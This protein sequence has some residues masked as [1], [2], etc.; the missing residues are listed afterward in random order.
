MKPVPLHALSLLLA[1]HAA[2]A[3]TFVVTRLDDP[4][5]DACV[6]GD[7]S[8]RE[9]MQAANSNDEFAPDDVIQLGA[10]SHVLIRGAL[11]IGQ[12]LD[13]R[14]AGSTQTSVSSDADLFVSG[15]PGR[16]NVTGMT[17]D[18]TTEFTSAIS[19]GS[20]PVEVDDVIV[21]RG[22]V[23]A[24]GDLTLRTSELRGSFQCSQAEGHCTVEDSHVASLYAV[25]PA[26]EPGATITIRRSIVDGE[27]R[28]DY[29][30]NGIV[31]HGGSLLV[32]D[33]LLMHLNVGVKVLYATIPMTLR[34][35]HYLDNDEPV[36]TEVA[37]TI[38]IED[39]LF[40]GNLVRALYAAG[41]A[42]W[43]VRGS[44][45]VNN[46][47]NGNAGGAIVIED[48]T[49]V[50]IEN[51]SFSGN[52]F[53]V[54]AAADG[55]RGGAIGFRNAT[56]IDLELRHV[57]I[58]PPTPPPAGAQGL[59]LGGVGGGSAVT[60]NVDNSILRGSCR[61]DAGA[62][63]HASGNI[64]SLGD[65]C[66]L[67][68]ASN[69]VNASAS[70]LAIGTLGD[71]GG[72]TPTYE[73]GPDSVAIDAGDPDRCLDTDQ[74]GYPRPFGA[75]CDVGAVEVGADDHLFSDGFEG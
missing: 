50:L 4:L 65:T 66:G 52:T 30:L 59:G 71:H 42:N 60:I 7:C 53:T 14:G 40:E 45:F 61:L 25:T 38:T 37:A 21:L 51:C 1:L 8:L 39:S 49:A 32:E 44:S 58:V 24:G 19:G 18:A 15:G 67:S 23:G 62:L 56:D 54:E 72:P 13:V 2:H 11:S 36:H 43:T 57:T 55:A 35:V 10:G 27:L 68:A 75:V 20:G 29:P 34:R 74:R 64:E 31:L 46:R 33:S 47:V 9:A 22:S 41:G 48:D 6:A 73:P 63:H 28:P 12:S 5:P 26:G 70:D 69:Q 3:E 16:L 17:L